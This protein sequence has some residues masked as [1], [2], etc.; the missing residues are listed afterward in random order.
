[1][2]EQRASRPAL[3]RGFG[4]FPTPQTLF[5][6][7]LGRFFPNIKDRIVKR[8]TMPRTTT[9]ASV[10]GGSPEGQGVSYLSFDAI[11][12]RNSKF[13]QL[14]EE[15]LEEL[16]GAEY[17]ALTALLWIVASVSICGY[18]LFYPDLIIH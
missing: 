3:Q 5:L 11:V 17:R 6:R 18:L 4:G 8:V 15:N 13:H 14:T 12:G 2:H 7:L 9:L 16:G 10:A 1:M